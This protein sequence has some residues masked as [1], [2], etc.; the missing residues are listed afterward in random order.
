M[1]RLPN[2]TLAEYY[3]R[4]QRMRGGSILGTQGMMDQPAVAPTVE[5]AEITQTPLGQVV[6]RQEEDN[7]DPA[8]TTKPM[9]PEE[10]IARQVERSLDKG[11]GYDDAAGG[12]MGPLGYAFGAGAEAF[13]R[14]AA[15]YQLGKKLMGDDFQGFED[16]SKAIELGASYFDDPNKLEGLLRSQPQLGFASPQVDD[17]FAPETT[18]PSVVGNLFGN[19]FGGASDFLNITR[20]EDE[21]K[22]PVYSS[23][24]EMRAGTSML[25]GLPTYKSP[26]L[27]TS[28]GSEGTFP[29]APP[30]SFQVEDNSGGGSL[31]EQLE[32]EV[33]N[34]SWMSDSSK[35]FI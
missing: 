32:Q 28:V 9:T 35:D 18:A 3:A 15:E 7:S 24:E 8:P 5:A 19:L 20:K 25:T 13:E 1:E 27:P 21:P 22:P 16:R 23:I 17:M 14:Q 10:I 29:V 6:V 33:I 26:A 34:D 31:A 11:V 30:P 12:L 4:L 2:E